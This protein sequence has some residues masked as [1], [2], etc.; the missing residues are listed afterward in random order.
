MTGLKLFRFS[1]IFIYFLIVLVCISVFFF[2][3]WKSGS[4]IIVVEID[5]K[6]SYLFDSTKYGIFEIKAFEEKKMLLEINEE[7]VRLI[8]SECPLKICLKKGFLGEYPDSIVC[9][10]LHAVIRFKG[11]IERN[12]KIDVLSQ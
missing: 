2:F 1:D 3:N 5:G 10:P 9:V 12:S 11:E 7:G 6:E 4:N 8:E